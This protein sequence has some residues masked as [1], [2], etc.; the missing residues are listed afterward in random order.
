MQLSYGILA[1]L[2]G[3]SSLVTASPTQSASDL[4]LEVNGK[5]ITA[6]ENTQTPTSRKKCTIANAEVR[7]DWKALSKKERKAYIKAVLCLRKRPSKAGPSFAPGARTTY[8]ARVR[9]V[10]P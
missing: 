9:R 5:A 2:L 1:A 6:R 7:R 10:S 4:M 3:A 8:I